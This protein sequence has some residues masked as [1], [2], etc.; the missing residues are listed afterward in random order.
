RLRA[1]KP[2]LSSAAGRESRR[3]RALARCQRHVRG[4]VEERA[5]GPD[6]MNEGDRLVTAGP[7]EDDAQYEAGLRPRTLDEYIGQDRLRANL[8]VLIEAARDRNEA[9]DRVLLYGTPARR[10]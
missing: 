6:E 9:G 5:A 3:R 1:R 2:G 4:R 8:E 7:V 10:A